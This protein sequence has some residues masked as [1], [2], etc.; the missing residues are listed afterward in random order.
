M[1]E[2]IANF[3][4][5]TA[6]SGSEVQGSVGGLIFYISIALGISFLCSVLEAVLLSTSLSHVELMASDGSRAGLLMRKH[7][8][9][10]ELPI[11]A[12]LTLN[13]IA[14]TVGAAGAGAQAAAVFGSQWLGV[15]SAVLT[16]L[17][18]VFSEIIPKT[19]GAV[20]WKQLMPFSAFTIQALVW[21]LFPVVWAFQKM[22]ALMAPEEREPTVTRSELEIL[23][24]VS[25][26]EGALQEK[27]SRILRNLLTLDGVQ[28]QHIMTP[29]TVM[30]TFQKDVPVHEV[31]EKHSVLSYSRIPVYAESADDISSFVL[32]HDI[33]KAAAEDRD[34][35]KMREIARP[36][37]SVPETLSVATVLE[38]FM[39]EQQHIYLVFD[40]Y[41]GTAGIVTL[42]DA[43]E[44]LLGAEIT[45]ESDRV[46]DLRELARR[47]YQR[48]F[49]LAEKSARNAD[50]RSGTAASEA[51][52]D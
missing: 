10:V 1:L 5:A 45:D 35:L 50:R 23:A 39:T 15:I 37:Q 6:S 36:M 48:Y 9:D 51:T 20:Y 4:A 19:L 40:E 16:L 42:E 14:H 24:L 34:Q 52:A 32:R 43:V 18:L 2:Q 22:T 38:K 29:R 41:G 44:S 17:I 8:Q 3:I 12:I 27:E 46:A 28:V 25:T 13:T 49:D 33:L 21:L 7:K 31:M 26:E 11:S 47:R 30:F